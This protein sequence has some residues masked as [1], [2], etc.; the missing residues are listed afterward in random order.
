MVNGK[1]AH[2]LRIFVIEGCGSPN[3]VRNIK[4]KIKEDNQ[5]ARK[6]CRTISQVLAPKLE[7][8]KI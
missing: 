6:T 7:H 2:A 1:C 4:E 5:K 8:D 3:C